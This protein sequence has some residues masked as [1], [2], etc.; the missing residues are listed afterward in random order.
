MG[1]PGG[2]AR[3]RR[4]KSR[5]ASWSGSRGTRTEMPARCWWWRRSPATTRRCCAIPCARCSREHDVW[6]TDWVN[7]RLVPL[8]AGPFHLAD[9][10]DYVRDWIRLLSPRPARHLGVPADGAGARRRFA[11]GGEERS[12]NRRDHGDDGRADRRAAQPDRGQQPGAAKAVLV[13]RAERDPAR[14]VEVPG[15][16]AARLPGLPAA[17]R[18]SWR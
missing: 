1:H 16:H 5:S 10:V 13:V 7:A 3:G 4:S 18:V 17:P 8:T 9:Y 14:A 2:A 6:V 11:D 15:L 12:R